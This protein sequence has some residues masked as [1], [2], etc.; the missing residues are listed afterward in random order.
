[1]EM[2]VYVSAKQFLL[3]DK[4]KHLANIYIHLLCLL[5][6]VTLPGRAETGQENGV[7]EDT[8]SPFSLCIRK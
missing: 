2:T 6:F 8:A 3:L 5:L 1:M 4:T 7:V